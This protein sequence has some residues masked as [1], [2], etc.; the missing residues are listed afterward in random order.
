[1]IDVRDDGDVAKLHRGA[2]KLSGVLKPLR[3]PQGA[4]ALAAI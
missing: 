3:A 1:M 4:R 2:I